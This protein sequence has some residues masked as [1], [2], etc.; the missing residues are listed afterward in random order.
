VTLTYE[1][2]VDCADPAM[3]GQFW[4]AA[5]GYREADVPEGYASWDQFDAEHG[6]EPNTGWDCYDPE[7]QKPRIFFQR[8]PEPKTVKNRLHLDLKV[9]DVDAEVERLEALGATVLR[10]VEQ[11]GDRWIVM[12]D[13]EGNEFCVA[14]AD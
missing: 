13:P 10:P 4:A 6:V 3:V 11:N 8:V 14:P 5:L 12:L 7:G 2:V 1:I 9:A